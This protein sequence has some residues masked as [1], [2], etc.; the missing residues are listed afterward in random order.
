MKK[1]NTSHYVPLAGRYPPLLANTFRDICA[2]GKY[3]QNEVL[4]EALKDW[5]ERHES[6]K[7]IARDGIK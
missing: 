3:I 6:G 4:I 7:W 1:K 2:R 5:I